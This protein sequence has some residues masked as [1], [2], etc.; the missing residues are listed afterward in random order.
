MMMYS[1]EQKI[2]QVRYRRSSTF[3]FILWL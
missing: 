3:Y 1:S 2:L